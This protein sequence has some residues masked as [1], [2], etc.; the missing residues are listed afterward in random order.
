MALVNRSFT[1]KH[2][3]KVSSDDLSLARAGKKICTIRLGTATVAGQIIDL[4]DGRDSLKVQIVSVET[5]CFRDLNEDHARSEG[6]SSLDDLRKDLTKY[7]G[8]IED[9]QPVT[10]ISFNPI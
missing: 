6:F 10:I 7:Y 8:R 1:Y 9:A 4:S 2:R 3:I 5:K